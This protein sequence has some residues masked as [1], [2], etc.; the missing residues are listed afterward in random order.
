[1]EYDPT[2]HPEEVFYKTAMKYDGPTRR[3]AIEDLAEKIKVGE[4]NPREREFINSLIQ[5]SLVSNEHVARTT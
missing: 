1:M 4:L 2:M 5:E 3:V